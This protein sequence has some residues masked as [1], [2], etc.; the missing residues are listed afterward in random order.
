MLNLYSYNNIIFWTEEQIHLRKMLETFFVTTLSRILKEQNSAFE[1]FQIEAPLL[2]PQALINPGYTEADIY[3][4]GDIALRPE[5]TMGSYA[6]AQH[7]LNPHNQRKARL[8][9][10]IWQHGKSFRREQDQPTKFVRLKEFHQLE[11]QILFHLSTKNDYSQVVVPGVCEMISAMIGP[12]VVQ[13]SDR[14]P[15]YAE[16]TQDIICVKSQMEVCSISMRK[17]FPAARNLEVAIGTD[18]CVFN[19]QNK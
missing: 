11:F 4:L 14:L 19:F 12:C 9:L 10:V 7:L 2:T 1:F 15:D 17:D 13:P 8:P 16:W 18:R 5:T 6:Y 3:S